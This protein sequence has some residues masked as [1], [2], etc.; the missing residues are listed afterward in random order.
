M[1][2]LP[3][4]AKVDMRKAVEIARIIERLEFK[5][6][7]YLD[8]NYY[9]PPNIDRELQLAY[10]T[11][12]VAVDHRT[13]IPPAK[14]E[15][16]IKGKSYKGSDLLYKLG[17]TLLDREPEFFKPYNLAEITIDEARKL[18][19]YKNVEVWDLNVR[20]ILLR[21]LGQKIVKYYNSKFTKLPQVKTIRE[22]EER[23]KIFRAYEDPLQK[24]THLL[25]KF[26]H[27]RGL[28]K[29]KD[30]ENFHIPV[31]NHITRITLRIG[32]VKLSNYKPLEERVE[33]PS[34]IDLEIRGKVR[35]A[36]RIIADITGLDPYTIDDNIWPLARKICTVEKAEC[37]SCPF[38]EVCI[39]R[40]TGH[41]IPEH[42][43]TL[44]WYY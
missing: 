16:V 14:F 17:K 33:L 7:R 2:E 21:D 41:Y 3:I 18:L 38:K 34:H 11:V 15:A 10:F 22:L 20:V 39:A 24:K 12:M 25:A 40:K 9:P 42:K 13:A 43:H 19:S 35:E 36:W 5:R 32:L 1:K 27:G 31:D 44:T 23:M 29:L 37:T 6:N 26:L 28:L 4:K 8:E 30:E